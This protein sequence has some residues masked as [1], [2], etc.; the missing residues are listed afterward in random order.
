MG[1]DGPDI[2]VTTLQQHFRTRTC[3]VTVPLCLAARH[4]PHLE[5]DPE[6]AG[7]SLPTLPQPRFPHVLSPWVT[8]SGD[9]LYREHTV[10]DLCHTSCLSSLT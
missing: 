6:L 4:R 2:K 8:S 1:A 7:R 5:G 3:C 9:F 10:C